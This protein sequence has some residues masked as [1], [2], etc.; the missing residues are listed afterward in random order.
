MLDVQT[1]HAILTVLDALSPENKQ[2]YLKMPVSK[3]ASV[4]WK[5]I[6]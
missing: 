1:A 2:K 3:M 5:L 6:S 4:A